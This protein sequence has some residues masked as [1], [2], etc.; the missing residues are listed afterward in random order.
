MPLKTCDKGRFLQMDEIAELQGIT[1]R[2]KCLAD[3]FQIE[4]SGTLN[5]NRS[6]LF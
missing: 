2:Y 1:G 3:D 4:L 5:G 6:F